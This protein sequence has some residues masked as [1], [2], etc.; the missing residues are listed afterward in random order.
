MRTTI[1]IDDALYRSVR[2]RAAET[3]RTIGGVIED[4]LRSALA[5]PAA[6]P[7]ELE[8]LPV[9]GGSGVMPGVDLA[10]NRRL[11]DL[12]DDDTPLVALR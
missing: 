9:F 3:G 10:D 7:A 2:L 6:P 8:P 12:L 11:A 4:A 5:R 1:R